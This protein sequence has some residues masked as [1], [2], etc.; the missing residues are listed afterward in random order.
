[1]FHNDANAGW[2]IGSIV[3]LTDSTDVTDWIIRYQIFISGGIGRQVSYYR[4]LLGFS[5]Q[6][7][8]YQYLGRLCLF[9][10]QVDQV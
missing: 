9:R 4:Q 10:L 8:L 5:A 2:R 1:M 3:Q 7:G 6:D